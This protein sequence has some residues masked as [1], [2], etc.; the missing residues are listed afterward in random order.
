MKTEIRYQYKFRKGTE[1]LGVLPL[2][3]N[4][5]AIFKHQLGN[6]T[7]SVYGNFEKEINLPNPTKFNNLNFYISFFKYKKGFG[8]SD[9]FGKI[10]LCESLEYKLKSVQLK[11]PY[12]DEATHPLPFLS[13]VIYNEDDDTF[14]IGV[15]EATSVFFPPKYWTQIKIGNQNIFKFLKRKIAIKELKTLDVKRYP[16][17][18]RNFY[19]GEWLNIQSIGAYK[20]KTLIYTNGGAATRS[21]SGPDFEFSILSE[22]DKD[23]KFIINHHLEKGKLFFTA[24]QDYFILLPQS[25]KKLIVYN[26]HN[27]Q[28]DY[29]VSLTP[30]QNLGM[31]KSTDV[32]FVNMYGNYLY[33][34]GKGFLNICKLKNK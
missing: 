1:V 32:Y 6:P 2:S 3:G 12:P 15:E 25:R 5:L 11:H 13:S 8:L 24:S 19:D 26:K 30:K 9:S 33:I 34:G 7:V 20:N 18:S 17:T 14:I 31:A 10:I 23:F 27:F 4:D 29:E 28:V 22:F 16:K 21:K